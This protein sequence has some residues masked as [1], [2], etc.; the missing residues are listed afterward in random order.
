[1]AHSKTKCKTLPVKTR[2]LPTNLLVRFLPKDRPVPQR[3]L[4]RSHPS[5]HRVFHRALSGHCNFAGADAHMCFSSLGALQPLG[6]ENAQ[7]VIVPLFFLVS[8]N[9]L[10]NN[11]AKDQVSTRTERASV[12]GLK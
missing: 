11:W 4:T 5:L 2:C 10:F 9:L 7:A 3:F 6:F 12:L 8:I 1:M